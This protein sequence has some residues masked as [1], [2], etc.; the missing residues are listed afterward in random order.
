MEAAQSE[1]EKWVDEISGRSP[2]SP[3]GPTS[4]SNREG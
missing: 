2:E 3:A 4:L 1:A